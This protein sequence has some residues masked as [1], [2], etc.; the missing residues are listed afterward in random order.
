MF[1]PNI[2]IAYMQHLALIIRDFFDRNYS[3]TIILL[4]ILIVE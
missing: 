2:K 3:K 4:D 1:I